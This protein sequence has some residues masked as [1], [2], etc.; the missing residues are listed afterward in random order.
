MTQP[1]T[2]TE[3]PA[4]MDPGFAALAAAEAQRSSP[5][6]GALTPA[7]M[8]MGYRMMRRGQDQ[9]PPQ[10]VE[11]RDLEIGGA[12]DDLPARL[13]TPARA[14][15]GTGLLVYFHGGGFVVGDLDSHDGHCRRLATY[16]GHRVLAVDYRLAPEHRFPA[17]HDDALAAIRWALAHAESL[18]A[19]PR[20]VAI[21]GDSAGANLALSAALDLRDE[22]VRPMFLLLL[23]PLTFPAEE[24]VSRQTFDGPVVNRA[25]LAGSEA[26]YGVRGHAQSHRALLDGRDLAGAPPAFV[27]TVG[28]DPMRDEGRRL[29]R[30]LSEA[31]AKTVAVEHP[32]LVHEFLL[33]P[34]LSATVLPIA[35]SLGRVLD[36]AL[37]AART[38]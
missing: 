25:A 33:M 1:T 35:E 29:A 2:E 38:G 30:R 5:P 16:S 8:R 11:T 12:E 23:Y 28:H 3:A 26:A 19:D 4:P 22:A 6:P 37:C 34:D 27:M 32:A 36:D 31:G 17:A 14:E 20:R 7:M 9:S 24:T 13:Y 10:D 21:G 18:G 15:V